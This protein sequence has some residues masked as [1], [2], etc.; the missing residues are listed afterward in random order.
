MQGSLISSEI[1]EPYAQALLSVAQ[2]NG[3]LDRFTEEIK[4][5]LG[6]LEESADLRDFIGNP[7]IKEDT[8]KAV[9]SRVLGD[10]THPFLANFI[11]LLIDKRRIQFLES[12][13]RQFLALARGLTNTALAE[14]SSA[15]EL[16]DG[17]RQTVIDRVKT[18]TGANVV[19]LK[20]TVNPDLIGGVVIKVGSQV[21][22]AS[23]RGQLQRLSLSL[24]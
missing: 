19:E 24:R 10:D 17:Q 20:T 15:T 23:I 4:S 2:S 3:L 12:V 9:L 6:V 21:F 11:Q 13:G 8:K 7:V 22:D 5:L 1:A 16:N 18:L 14:V